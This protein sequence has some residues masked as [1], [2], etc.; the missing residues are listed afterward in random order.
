MGKKVI[1]LALIGGAVFFILKNKK[2]NLLS[3]ESSKEDNKLSKENNTDKSV[4]DLESIPVQRPI[5]QTPNFN[6]YGAK[7]YMDKYLVTPERQIISVL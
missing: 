2:N 6:P 3:I 7:S 1:L 5:F 4:L